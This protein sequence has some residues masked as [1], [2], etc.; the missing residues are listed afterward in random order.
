MWKRDECS[1]L[2]LALFIDNVR[3]EGFRVTHI[4]IS[5]F[6]NEKLTDILHNAQVD[7]VL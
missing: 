4:K 3:D 2:L 7:K 1:P 5:A 6:N